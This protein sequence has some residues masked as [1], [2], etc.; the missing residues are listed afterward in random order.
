MKDKKTVKTPIVHE[1]ICKVCGKTFETTHQSTLYCPDCKKS[2]DK[3]TVEKSRASKVWR[4]TNVEIDG[5]RVTAHGLY[6]FTAEEAS[7]YVDYCRTKTKLPLKSI[8]I[9][10]AE[11]GFVDIVC[12]TY[13]FPFDRIKRLGGKID[14]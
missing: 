12:D 10:E 3:A 2:V 1:N 9:A 4:L 14:R 6:D 5:I 11:G 13:K 7:R 8:L